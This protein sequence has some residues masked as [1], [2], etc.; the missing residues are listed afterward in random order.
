MKRKNLTLKISPTIVTAAA[1]G[2]AG[3]IFMV[4][5]AAAGFPG[6]TLFLLRLSMLFATRVSVQHNRER[7]IRNTRYSQHKGRREREL[8]QTGR[9]CRA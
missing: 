3:L 5:A 8:F 7:K 4:T 1:A 6:F 9:I 2:H